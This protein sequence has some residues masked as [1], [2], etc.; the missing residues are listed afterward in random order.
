MQSFQAMFKQTSV[1][2]INQVI[3]KKREE[4]VFSVQDNR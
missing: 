4:A 1:T 3:K 2:S